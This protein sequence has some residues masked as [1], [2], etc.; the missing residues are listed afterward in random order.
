MKLA[1]RPLCIGIVV[2]TI[3]GLCIFFGAGLGHS[4]STP[5][6]SFIP[7][8]PLQQMQGETEVIELQ[9][10][11]FTP[12][13]IRRPQGKF[14]LAVNNRSSAPDVTFLLSKGTG[15]AELQH[16]KRLTRVKTWRQVVDL[17]PGRYVLQVSNHPEWT[18]DVTI[19]P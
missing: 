3:C 19:T 17:K 18:C 15:N 6:L 2:L 9:D 5:S 16:Q 1:L 4:S 11:G 14:L 7:A 13:E 12:A 10:Q 8:V